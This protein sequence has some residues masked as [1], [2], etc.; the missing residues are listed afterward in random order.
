MALSL[1]S[2]LSVLILACSLVSLGLAVMGKFIKEELFVSDPLMCILIGIALRGLAE[3]CD[4]SS[5]KTLI[6]S[7]NLNVGLTILKYSAR[8]IM[9]IQVMAVGESLKLEYLRDN[10]QS[11]ILLTIFGTFGSFLAS[12]AV[13]SLAC[14]LGVLNKTP[15]NTNHCG[16]SGAK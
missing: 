12:W 11:F 3:H 2:L 6:T 1:D 7:N 14:S 5:I 16:V 15:R 13:L 8:F 10:M 9:A 4:R